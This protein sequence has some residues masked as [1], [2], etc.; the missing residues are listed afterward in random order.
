MSSGTTHDENHPGYFDVEAFILA[1]G[2]SSRMGRAKHLLDFEGEPL[3][4]RMAEIAKP[5]VKS[6]AIV[7]ATEIH[8]PAA[9][10]AIPDDDLGIP[11][12]E[13]RSNGPLV[14]IATALAHSRSEW[15][16]ILA[17]DLPYVTRDWLAWLFRRAATSQA[18]IVMPVTDRG[19]EPLAAI[20]RR[21]CRQTIIR[22][23]ED[24]IRKVTAAVSRLEVETVHQSE[25]R[26]IDPE[27]L[28]L[29]NMNNPADYEEARLW[30]AKRMHG[31]AEVR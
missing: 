6:V 3:I 10:R 11:R 25:W 12:E 9:I 24:G 22:S 16:L 31:A 2:T 1:G 4:C 20:Y 8:L 14:G 29:R 28:V 18:Q 21:N 7:G 30:R 19:P 27:D 17:C 5:L 13:G 26:H 15:N 23:L